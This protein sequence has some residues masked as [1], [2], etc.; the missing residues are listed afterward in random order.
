MALYTT[1]KDYSIVKDYVKYVK[2]SVRIE[3]Q[4]QELKE[5]KKD[6][7]EDSPFVVVA[8]AKLAEA[9]T[10]AEDVLAL[11]GR[12]E[13]LEQA[14]KD[15]ITLAMGKFTKELEAS[16][17]FMK[18]VE[19]CIDRLQKNTVDANTVKRLC[20]AA[21]EVL[22]KKVKPYRE[23]NET[24]LEGFKASRYTGLRLGKSDPVKFAKRSAKQWEAQLAL[25]I[26][27]S[28]QES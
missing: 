14:E 28:L 19:N 12:Y 26:Y 27:A 13:A 8:A 3:E 5:L 20:K 24:I 9:K 10:N 6:L 16:E 23:A 15:L 7:G 21:G 2:T 17:A 1:S 18:E 25:Y 22:G 4:E 11:K